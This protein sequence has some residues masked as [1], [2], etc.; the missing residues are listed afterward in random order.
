MLAVTMVNSSTS[1]LDRPRTWRTVAGSATLTAFALGVGAG[2][3]TV[4]N[5]DRDRCP[6]PDSP[7]QE[8]TVQWPSQTQT[9]SS[10]TSNS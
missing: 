6:H 2:A 1:Q 5:L 10:T 7:G 4:G 3:G 8:M 9:V